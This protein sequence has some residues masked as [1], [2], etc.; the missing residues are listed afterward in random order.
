MYIPTLESS[1]GL[2]VL[3]AAKKIYFSHDI[4]VGKPQDNDI[5][6]FNQSFL[7]ELWLKSIRD[8]KI[9]SRSYWHYFQKTIFSV[10]FE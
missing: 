2:V 5:L 9:E 8:D 4:P 6:Q 7:L 1:Q 3:D 10:S